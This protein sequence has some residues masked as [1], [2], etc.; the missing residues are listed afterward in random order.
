M[1]YAFSEE[2]LLSIFCL[3]VN[4]IDTILYKEEDKTIQNFLS[5]SKFLRVRVKRK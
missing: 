2:S 4:K 1:F 5:L 3:F